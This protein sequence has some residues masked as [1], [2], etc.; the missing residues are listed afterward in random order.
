MSRTAL[1]TNASAS[2]TALTGGGRTALSSPKKGQAMAISDVTIPYEVLLRYGDGGEFKAAHVQYR[3]VL[4]EGDTILADPLLD[5][6]PLAADTDPAF[7]DVIGKAAT[8]ALAS[9]SAG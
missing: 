7:A 5:A 4:S 6:V 9:H 3:R 8:S 2:P 1:R